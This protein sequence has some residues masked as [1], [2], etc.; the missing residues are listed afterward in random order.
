MQRQRYCIVATT[1]AIRCLDGQQTHVQVPIG[2]LV[3][4]ID[5]PLDT[6]LLAHVLW[7]GT[8]LMM[9]TQDLRRRAEPVAL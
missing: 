2:A 4:L 3:T 6:N 5:G 1:F 9:F 8:D 7:S